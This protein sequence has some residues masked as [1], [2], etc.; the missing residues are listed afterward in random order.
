MRTLIIILSVHIFSVQTKLLYHLNGGEV[1]SFLNLTEQTILAMVFAL[2]YSAATAVVM[3]LSD[4][5][6]LII[7]YAGM[8]GLAVLLYYFKFIPDWFSAFY[9]AGYTFLLIYSVIAVKRPE[10]A[11]DMYNKGMTLKDIAE[12]LNISVSTASRRVQKN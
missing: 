10:N 4:D 7:I 9:F 11:S 6:R 5:S 3:Y 1:F 2:S 12:K 8:D